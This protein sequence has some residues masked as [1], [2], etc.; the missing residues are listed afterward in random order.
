MFHVEL[1]VDEIEDV[2][3][4]VVKVRTEFFRRRKL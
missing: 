2:F 3:R 1:Q 4:L